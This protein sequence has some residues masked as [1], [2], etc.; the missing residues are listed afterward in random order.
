[1]HFHDATRKV[2]ILY[3]YHTQWIEE[4][5]DSNNDNFTK[6]LYWKKKIGPDVENICGKLQN[7]IK[8]DSWKPHS[9]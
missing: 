6:M 7:A 4:P 9:F 5:G 1:M 2:N 3:N 8:I